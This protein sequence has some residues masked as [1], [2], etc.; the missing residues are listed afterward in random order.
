M[1]RKFIILMAFLTLTN[2]T[3][4]SISH[5]E[6]SIKF[7]ALAVDTTED[8]EY[9]IRMLEF[10]KFRQTNEGKLLQNQVI[11]YTIAENRHYLKLA[12]FLEW[13]QFADFTVSPKKDQALV[14]SATCSREAAAAQNPWKCQLYASILNQEGYLRGHDIEGDFIRVQFHKTLPYAFFIRD[15]AGDSKVYAEVYDMDGK[16]IQSIKSFDESM[17][18][19]WQRK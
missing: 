9:T 12:P 17:L 4:A 15:S 5:N 2:Q 16:R 11:P 13:L 10:R 14:Y 3:F 8:K 1:L 18:I 6:S 19:G 7:S